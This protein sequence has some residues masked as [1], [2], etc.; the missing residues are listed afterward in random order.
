MKADGDNQTHLHLTL[1]R[2]AHKTP[3]FEQYQDQGTSLTKSPL[4][5]LGLKADTFDY[6]AP[7]GA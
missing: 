3:G 1:T 2:E 4:A 7:A 6:T 5:R